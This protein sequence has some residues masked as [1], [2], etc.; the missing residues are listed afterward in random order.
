MM[1][2]AQRTADHHQQDAGAKKLAEEQVRNL[3]LCSQ[4]AYQYRQKQSMTC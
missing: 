3:D 2:Y 4:S 1:I